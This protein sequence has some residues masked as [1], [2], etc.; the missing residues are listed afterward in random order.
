MKFG[1][2]R[3]IAIGIAILVGVL[4]YTL[5]K[6]SSSKI[7]ESA[8]KQPVERTE[9]QRAIDLVNG[10]VSPMEGIQILQALVAEDSTNVEAHLWLGRFSV[11]SGQLDKAVSRF[12]TILR[13]EPDH[14]QGNWEMAMLAWELQDWE[15]AHDKFERT[16]SLDSTYY[17][18]LF[19]DGQCLERLERP[20]EAMVVYET[21]LPK[22]EDEAVVSW[23]VEKISELR[24]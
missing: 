19:F 7:E 23:L 1:V 15:V 22:S 14:L 2:A 10:G 8:N 9:L 5:P 12:Q 11:Q 13:I 16:Y 20:S 24:N 4:L 17:N 6:Q 18:A 21:L 3:P